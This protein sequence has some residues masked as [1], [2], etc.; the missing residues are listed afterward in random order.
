MILIIAS[1]VILRHYE[2]ALVINFRLPVYH[3]PSNNLDSDIRCERV[4]K[5]APVYLISMFCSCLTLNLLS[6]KT[7]FEIK[8]K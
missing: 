8:M 2:I 5:S 1:K 3:I 7:N 4:R 6:Q